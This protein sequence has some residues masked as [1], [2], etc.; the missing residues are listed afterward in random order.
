[1]SS[2]ES[3]RPEGRAYTIRRLDLQVGRNV[4]VLA[5]LLLT[6]LLAYQPAWSGGILWDDEG[7]LT[8]AELASAGGL[9]RIWFEPGATQQYY[10]VVHTAFWI[11]NALWG[12]ATTGYHLVNILL[13]ATSAWLLWLLL[14]RLSIPGGLIAA[15][16]FA[17]HPVHVESVA[18]ITELK[19]V[20]SGVFYLSAFLFYTRW[21][22][23]RRPRTWWTAFVLFALAVFSKTVTVTLPAAVLVV[24]W[25]RHGKVDLARDGRPLIPFFVLGIAAG[26]MT[27][28][29]ERTF[30]G[31]QGAEFEL[32]AL[33]R[34]LLAG[35]VPWFYLGKLLWPADLIFIYPRWT[36]DPG[37]VAWWIPAAV[38][39]LVT[40]AAWSIRRRSRTPLAVILLF[41]GTLFPA[42]GFFNVY[43]FRFSFVADHFQYLASIAIIV[44]LA[45]LWGQTRVRPRSDPSPP[46]GVRPGSDPAPSPGVRRG[47]DPVTAVSAAGVKRGSDPSPSSGVKRGSDPTDA[48][49]RPRSDPGSAEVVLAVVVAVVLGVLTWQQAHAYSDAETL[50]RDTIARNPSAWIAH[51]NLASLLLAGE[52]PRERIEESIGHLQRAIDL[53]PDYAEAHYNL[54]TALE[55]LE[56]RDEAVAAYSR[57][58]ALAPGERRVLQRLAAVTHDRASARLEQALQLENAGRLEEA[59]RIYED[60]VGID[61]SR[62]VIHR[63]IGRVNQ[64]LGRVDAAVAAYGRALRADPAS[65]ET[66]NDLGV[67]LAQSGRLR[68]ALRHF[69]EAVKLRPSDPDARRNLA[70]AEALLTSPK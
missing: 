29:M 69:Q 33:Q 43:P 42:L 28:W 34:V 36:I 1:M 26:L 18:W 10:P 8:R 62:A 65:F 53:K 48:G 54:G 20:L 13:H 3:A 58:L 14:R 70:Q 44:G 60:A 56:R 7:H 52:P 9:S 2:R 63:S 68:E 45:A 5:T 51:N 32:S 40:A 66:H 49:V 35:T 24:I 11:M 37:S 30:I 39:G 59:L 17:L 46:P 50:Y 38:L 12:H 61:A 27:V 64:K 41:V 22:D 25:W 23:D 47:S 16:V 57:A 55:R 67:L 15:A 31:A 6:T 19:N 21:L 4:L